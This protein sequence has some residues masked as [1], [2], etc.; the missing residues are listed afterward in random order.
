MA[1]LNSIETLLDRI[2]EILSV[3][4]ENNVMLKQIVNMLT[5]KAGENNGKSE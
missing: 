4:N 2:I 5:V 3:E 1:T